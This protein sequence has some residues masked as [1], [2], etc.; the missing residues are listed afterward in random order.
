MRGCGVDVWLDRE[1]ISV[2]DSVTLR[3]SEGLEESEHVIL[4]LSAN[5]ASSTW[6]QR[7]WTSALRSE[8]DSGRVIVL[9]ARI[10]DCPV[11]S[12]LADKEL[13]DFRKDYHAG[14]SQLVAAFRGR[15]VDR[16]PVQV[17]SAATSSCSLLLELK[18]RAREDPRLELANL[19][20]TVVYSS[21]ALVPS[22]TPD[23]LLG[24]W[25]S[26]EGWNE[27]ETWQFTKRPH[28]VLAFWADEM[29]VGSTQERDL[30]SGAVAWTV[31]LREDVAAFYWRMALG[32]G[33][34]GATIEGGWGI[35]QDLGDDAIDGMWW[36][37]HPGAGMLDRPPGFDDPRGTAYYWR[38]CRPP[39]AVEQR[40]SVRAQR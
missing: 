35:L 27:G 1:K 19:L 5:S 22:D 12:I 39:S 9:P 33:M 10:D 28:S 4:I 2:G 25:H 40:L 36:Y 32:F 26:L 3:I 11:P 20:N 18:N 38:L 15:I 14:L 34:G 24:R 16:H 29:A 7:E 21:V 8:I 17:G 31:P 23:W 6:V 30:T 13:A 37:E